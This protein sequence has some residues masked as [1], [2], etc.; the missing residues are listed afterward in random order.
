MLHG[1]PVEKQRLKA[2]SQCVPDPARLKACPDTNRF[3]RSLEALRHPKSVVIVSGLAAR[4]KPP[5]QSNFP[6][7][8]NSELS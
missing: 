7:S 8:F 3:I 1:Q 6:I 5:F 4:L 2:R